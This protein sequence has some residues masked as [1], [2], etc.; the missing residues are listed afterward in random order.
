LK[1]PIIG[2]IVSDR[3][4]YTPYVK[5]LFF[6]GCRPSEAIALK[7]KH[8]TKQVKESAK[9]RTREEN[10]QLLKDAEIND[11]LGDRL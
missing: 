5:F 7:W 2:A 3:Y 11:I 9:N 1:F 8:I 4:Y 6:T 10:I